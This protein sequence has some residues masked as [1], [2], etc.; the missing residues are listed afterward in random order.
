M[1]AAWR[2]LDAVQLAA[3]GALLVLGL[4][5]LYAAS[6]AEF[7]TQLAGLALGLAAFAGFALTD[8]RRLRAAA[9][10]LYGAALLILLAV[11]AAGHVSYGA[12]R[13]IRVAGVQ[14]QPSELAKLLLLVVLAAYL[15][16]R[17]RVGAREMAVTAGLGVPPALL[18]LFQP[19]LGTAIV[20]AALIVGILFLAGAPRPHLA[21]VV[22][23]GLAAVPILPHVLHGY[24]RRRLEVFLDPS[25]DPLGAGY[26]LIQAR[27]A[28]GSG[29]VFGQGWLH[30][31]QGQLGYVPERTSDFVFAVFAEQFGLAGCLILL[32][33]FAV[34]L[35]RMARSAASAP[36]RFG[37]LL[38]AGAAVIFFTQV[39]QNVGMNVGLTPIAGI[40]LPFISHGSS[41]LVTEMALLGLVQSVMLRRRRLEGGADSAVWPAVEVP[42]P[43]RPGPYAAAA[44]GGSARRLR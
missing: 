22:A 36:D 17:E 28:V 23:A 10:Y 38:C 24:Q 39:A 12:Q 25:R 6:A 13:W 4:M 37:E 1:S 44:P 29:G 9:P 26:N 20:F 43:S 27:I 3:A 42:R 18:V 30:G 16:G 35:L 15:A 5:T 41:A 8:Y 34:L 21:G 40:P 19:D 2:R 31:A 32:A 11:E 33:L 7:R 14:V